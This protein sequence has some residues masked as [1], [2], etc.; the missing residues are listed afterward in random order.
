MKQ[1]FISLETLR[2]ISALNILDDACFEGVWLFE[3]E[4]PEIKASRVAFETTLFEKVDLSGSTLT[5][6]KI[7][8]A[9]I[10]FSNL[11]NTKSKKARILRT[12]FT[13]CR[14]TGLQLSEAKFQ[15]TLFTRCKV[16][17]ACFRF[18]VLKDVVFD[19]CIL[20]S[21]DFLGAT[22]ERVVFRNCDLTDSDF[23]QVK[24][25]ELNLRGSKLQ[26]I[27]L[28]KESITGKVK[29]DAGQA[30]YLAGLFGL[31]IDD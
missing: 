21:S 19:E 6:L 28:Q 17:L 13:S 8:N 24:I 5:E 15:D 7:L 14:L 11:A 16:D 10:R 20:T 23:S 25:K 3:S 18:G 29:V 9:K 1:P 27:H 12:E 31:I 2:Q 30:L 22:L 26:S 4:S